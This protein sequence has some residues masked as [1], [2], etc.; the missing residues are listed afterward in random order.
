[1]V[2]LVIV[3][4]V[5]FIVSAM[6]V[7]EL[8]PMVEQFGGNAGLDEL[9]AALREARETAISERRTIVIKFVGKSE[10][11]L[12]QITEPGNT[13]AATP[14]DT[15]T[16]G[17]RAQFL[18]VTGETDTPDGYVPGGLT[19][20]DGVYADNLDGGPTTMEFQSDG[21][22]T[23][24]NGIP[25]NG[26]FFVGVPG[27]NTAGRAATILGNTGRVRAWYWNGG[28]WTL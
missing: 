17:A 23:D 4:M 2:E 25:I 18:T 15:V 22:F 7:I 16:L 9:K 27:T 3:V 24:Q 14:F 12:F 10:I 19:V 28:G 13:V 11:E 8:Q 20:P 26:T 6:A 1:M 5:M 21:T